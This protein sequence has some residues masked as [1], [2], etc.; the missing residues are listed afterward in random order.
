MNPLC[1]VVGFLM[2]WTL[3]VVTARCVCGFIFE[4]HSIA[5]ISPGTGTARYDKVLSSTAQ[6]VGSLEDQALG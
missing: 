4:H 5:L 2:H 1:G 3:A 6:A